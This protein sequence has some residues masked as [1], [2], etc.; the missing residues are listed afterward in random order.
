MDPSSTLQADSLH[1]CH[2]REALSFQQLQMPCKKTSVR[3]QRV[4]DPSKFLLLSGLNVACIIYHK[5]LQGKNLFSLYL[6]LYSFHKT[7]RW[8]MGKIRKNIQ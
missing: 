3:P 2:C 5:C 8:G 4:V 7:L 6:F 1:S